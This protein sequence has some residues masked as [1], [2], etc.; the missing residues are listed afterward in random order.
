[1][2]EHTTKKLAKFAIAYLSALMLVGTSATP[3]AA[4][5]PTNAQEKASPS[6][7]TK[8]ERWPWRF[9]V[10][11]YAWLP[12]APVD[13]KVD[14]NEVSNYPESFDNIFD[15]LQMASMSEFEVHKGPVGVFASPIY[16]KGEDHENFTGLAGESRKA[17]LDEK[18][19]LIKY[20]ASYDLGPWHLGET[21]DSPTVVLQPYAGGLYLHD[22]IELKVSPGLFD[23]GLD[24]KTTISINTPIIGLNTLW[25]LTKRWTL[26]LGGNYGGWDVDDMKKTYEF[27]G[28]VGYRFKMWDVSSKVFA[29][30]RYLHVDYEKRDVELQ[31]DIKGPLFGIG[32]EF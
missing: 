26:R 4:E 24:Y 22:D 15:S 9:I 7:D 32:W 13:I 20:G 16:Y 30:Y 14:G 8:E 25:D 17:T 6:A 31:V 1:M 28:T 19:W 29:G 3:S 11:V 23:I 5:E 2:R 27:V 12:E 10:N 18:V 21:S